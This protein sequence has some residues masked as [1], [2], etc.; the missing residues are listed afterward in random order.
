MMCAATGLNVMV[1][2]AKD[3]DS[4]SFGRA[5]LVK[6]EAVF[7]ISVLTVK[8]RLFSPLDLS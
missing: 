5:T 2:D 8:F 3:S 4:G 1:C 6:V 7:P